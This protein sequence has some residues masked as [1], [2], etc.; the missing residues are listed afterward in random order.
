MLDRIANYLE[1]RRSLR[2]RLRKALSYP[3]AVTGIALIVTTI[4]LVN[5]IPQFTS[6]FKSTGHHLPLPTQIIIQLANTIRLHGWILLLL[7]FSLISLGTQLYRHSL[8]FHRFIDRLWLKVP[9][10]GIIAEKTIIARFCRTLAITL[11]AGI[12]LL[13]ALEII[14]KVANNLAYQQAILKIRDEVAAGEQFNYAMQMTAVF[15]N[16]IVSMMAIGEESGELDTMAHKAASIYEEDVELL[17]E[18]LSHLL[19]PMIMSILGI[20]IG[21]LVIAMY[22]PIFKLGQTF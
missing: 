2:K 6:L 15:P 19:E 21:G 18:N 12:P 7:G 13:N 3:L 22:L 4:L 9:I 10:F 11:A 1:R 17:V 8:K 5:V 16:A 14:A 20:L